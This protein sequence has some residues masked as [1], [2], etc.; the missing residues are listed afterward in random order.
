MEKAN[1]KEDNLESILSMEDFE[2]LDIDKAEQNKA[3]AK[4]VE[5]TACFRKENYSGEILPYGRTLTITQINISVPSDY[6]IFA[7]DFDTSFPGGMHI[8]R[9]PGKKWIWT[10]H[11]TNLHGRHRPIGTYN[12]WVFSQSS[13]V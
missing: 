3:V 13:A 10:L 7:I 5:T 1:L 9:Y 4:S 12:I 2:P 6:E 8:Q 11:V